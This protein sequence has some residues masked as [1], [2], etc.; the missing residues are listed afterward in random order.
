[1]PRISPRRRLAERQAVGLAHGRA[2]DDLRRQAKVTRQPANDDCLLAVLL[3]EVRPIGADE[4]KQ[5]RD[6]RR[7]A[8]QV[9]RP[10]RPLEHLCQLADIDARA[11]TGRVDVLDAGHEADVHAGSLEQCQVGRLVARVALVVLVRAELGGVDEDARDHGRALLA[12]P[13]QEALMPGVQRAHR[14][15]EADRRGEPSPG[16]GQLGAVAHDLHQAARS[17]GAASRA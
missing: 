8:A 11:G 2:D 4:C 17:G 14:G 7:H 5:D 10:G 6:H 15:H 12:G 16:S 1:V 3:A 9:A 13:V